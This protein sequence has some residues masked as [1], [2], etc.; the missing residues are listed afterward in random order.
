[1]SNEPAAETAAVPA[2]PWVRRQWRRLPALL[3]AIVVGWLI[4]VIGQL[5]PSALMWANLELW[6]RFPWF[7]IGTIL[8]LWLFWRWLDGRGP[9]RSTAAS[10]R[11]DLRGRSLSWRVWLWALVAGGLGTVSVMGLALLTG[12]VAD[13]PPA[14]YE[15]PF[16]LTPYSP[17]TAAAVLVSIAAV[18]GVVEEA[19]FRGYML[20]GIERRLGWGAAIGITALLFYI[21]H[22]NHAYATLAFLPFFALYGLLQGML[23]FFTRSILPSVVLHTTGDLIV[24]PMQYGIVPSPLGADLTPAWLVVAICAGAALA[25]FRG[26]AKVTRAAR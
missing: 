16:D 13:L 2:R 20:S 7:L 1:M 25:A 10:R 24:L 15:P 4:L 14:A 9:P 12:R 5:P 26:L 21:A 23:V 8:W 17:W 18:A 19:A 22:L 11:R 6:P 3:R